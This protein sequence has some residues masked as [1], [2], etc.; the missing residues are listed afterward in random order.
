[1]IVTGLL[2][3]RHDPSRRRERCRSVTCSEGC[4]S[5]C[6]TPRGPGDA[7]SSKGY[8]A[9]FVLSRANHASPLVDLDKHEGWPSSAVEKIPR[10]LTWDGRVGDR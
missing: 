10:P 2:S 8:R 7:D 3:L 9:V 4:D 5:I 1:M 6:G